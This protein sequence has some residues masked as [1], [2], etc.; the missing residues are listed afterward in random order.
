VAETKQKEIDGMTFSVVKFTSIEALRLKP[1]LL[2]LFGPALGQLVNA[3]GGITQAKSF[4]SLVVD[5]S[6]IALA[7][8]KLAAELTEDEFEQLIKRLLKNVTCTKRGPDGQTLTF[9]LGGNFESAMDNVFQGHLFTVYP[10]IFFVLESNYPDFFGKAASFG[11]QIRTMLSSRKA[12][13]S[14][15]SDSSKSETSV[16]SQMT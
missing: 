9:V 2:R 14:E 12:D 1:Y 10:V 4:D 6:A 16:S 11:R 8:E 7:I 5:G 15:T 3:V 13:E